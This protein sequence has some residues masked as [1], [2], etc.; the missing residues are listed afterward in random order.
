LGT[1]RYPVPWNML[2]YDTSQDGYVVPLEKS[3]LEGGAP[4][5]KRRIPDHDDAYRS[6]VDKYHGL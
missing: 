4:I 5:R 2:K 6:N 3:Q 1:D